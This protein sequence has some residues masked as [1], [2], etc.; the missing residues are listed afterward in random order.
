MIEIDPNK[1]NECGFCADECPSRIFALAPGPDGGCAVQTE[2][3]DW[4]SA[5]GHCVAICPTGAIVHAAFAGNKFEDLPRVAM[6]PDAVRTFLLSR[7]SIR[8]FKEKPVAR[9]AIEQLIEV[10]VHAGTATNAQTE[11]FIVVQDQKLL[12]E[13]EQMVIGIFMGQAEA[14]GK[15]RRTEDSAH[16][17]RRRNGAAVR[18]VL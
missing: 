2:Y 13:L 12:A 4:C 8:A 17:I 1:C 5:C 16:E 10:G 6:A 14:L 3:L 15:R 18:A 7:R 9:E 11:N